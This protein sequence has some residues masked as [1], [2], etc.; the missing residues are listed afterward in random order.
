M[1]AGSPEKTEGQLEAASSEH[2]PAIRRSFEVIHTDRL[3]RFDK[4]LFGIEA[5]DHE[6]TAA[7]AAEV[8]RV[9]IVEIGE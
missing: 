2:Y 3:A 4:R 8:A 9:V 5:L 1:S 7:I 6:E